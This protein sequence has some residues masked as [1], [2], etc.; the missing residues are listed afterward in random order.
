MLYNQRI[1]HL[2]VAYR[3]HPMY[4]SDQAKQ[5]GTEI[6]FVSPRTFFLC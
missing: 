5:S 4:I 6:Q 3:S 1:F 2:G